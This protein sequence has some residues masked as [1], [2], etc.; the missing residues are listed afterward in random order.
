MSQLR[1][2]RASAQL[3]LIISNGKQTSPMLAMIVALF[4]LLLTLERSSLKSLRINARLESRTN[5]NS[6]KKIRIHSKPVNQVKIIEK[7]Q[8]E[9]K[10]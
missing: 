6:Q 9:E 10:I 8:R 4:S 7:V 2:Q 1:R 5:E 3:L